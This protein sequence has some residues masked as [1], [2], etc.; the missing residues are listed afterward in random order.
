MLNAM[1]KRK[2]WKLTCP[3]WIKMWNRWQAHA[4]FPQPWWRQR[5]PYRPV[6]CKRPATLDL[7]TW[8]LHRLEQT[9]SHLCQ[10]VALAK[11]TDTCAADA[12]LASMVH[13]ADGKITAH[14]HY[15]SISQC[16]LGIWQFWMHLFLAESDPNCVRC[17]ETVRQSLYVCF[18]VRMTSIAASPKYFP[19]HRIF[20]AAKKTT[21]TMKLNRISFEL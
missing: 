17:A 19:F 15:L 6:S 14:R 3:P 18:F 8:Y 1:R 13:L 11:S 20:G 10:L 5:Y 16:A 21:T 7:D 4:V 2:I 12:T 9:E